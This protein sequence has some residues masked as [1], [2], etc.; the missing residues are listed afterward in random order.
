MR[1]QLLVTLISVFFICSNVFSQQSSINSQ[2]I[3]QVKVDE[4]SDEQIQKIINQAEQSGMT[5]QQLEQMV[6]ARGLPASELQKLKLRIA[7]LQNQTDQSQ[8]SEDASGRQ[9]KDDISVR[10]SFDIMNEM[11][12]T[13]EDTALTE[14]DKLKQK[15]FG[16][17]LFNNEKLT[18]SP[19]LNIATPENYIIGAGD[20]INIDIWGASQQNYSL[21]VN[22]EGYIFID[23]L[24]PVYLSGLSIEKANAKIKDKLSSI[25]SGLSGESPNTFL[26]VSLGD[27][28]S[29]KVTVSGDVNLP[30]TYSLPALATAFNALYYAGGPSINGSF[31]EVKIIR[32]GKEFSKFDLYDF[33]VKGSTP[34]NIRL[35][36]ED[37]VFIP[38]CVKRVEIEG[39]VVRPGLYEFLEEESLSDLI[40][41]SGGFKSDAYKS[42]V[43]IFRKGDKQKEVLDIDKKDFEQTE[44]LD[45]DVLLI[46]PIL[47]KYANR[48][49]IRGAV[50]RE[51]VFA[52]QENMT[53]KQLIEKA[54]GYRE[55]AFLTRGY[56]YRLGSNY[57]TEMISFDPIKL[58][59][60]EAED[61]KLSREDFI[62]I[63]SLL[64][65][66]EE[67]LV[68]LEGEVLN[69]GE[70]PYYENLKLGEILLEAG[71]LL[72]SA[73]LARIEVARRIRNSEATK[74]TPGV[75]EVFQ[76][77][78][79]KSL[80]INDIASDF[81]LEPFDVIVIRKSPDYKE[82]QI[83]TVEG[84]VAFPGE[85]ILTHKTERISDIINRAGG[86]TPEAYLKGATLI[87][88][89]E[90]DNE[91][92]RRKALES[93]MRESAD[94]AE[95]DVPMER[96]QAIGI[97]L[98][99]I[100]AGPK[101]KYDLL[102]QEG[103]ILRIPKQL[104]TVRL[105]GALL[106]PVTV[107]YDQMKLFRNYITQAG[108]FASNAK[109]NKA[110]I[111]YAN[112]SVNRTQ[113][114][115]FIRDFPKVEPGAEIVIPAKPPK[116]KMTP[117][118]WVGL[119][120]VLSSTALVLVTVIDKLSN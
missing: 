39:E 17:S 46:D 18:F 71:G 101:S 117:Q 89:V 73:S 41:Y 42:R 26:Q 87:R 90:E 83:I 108:G 92:N 25:Y 43:K 57:K 105:S 100:L 44:L 116:D 94:S 91:E 86:F 74:P 24:G 106:Y 53:L 88:K 11:F 118:E 20:E 95:F 77:P 58:L 109:R 37:I 99:Q 97:D 62:K 76:F 5:Q 80:N 66:E 10:T 4:L 3:S 68:I 85:Y 28:K 33:L 32:G 9:L 13:E 70:Y 52:L 30:G 78:I 21:A 67:K 64:D 75:A 114:F 7:E 49:E 112:G 102:L 98:Q 23:A 93:I 2:D 48:V 36:D 84:E 12:F 60:G 38:P 56:I 111:I 14:E 107:R 96:E 54:E 72:E 110:Y 63:P 119:T 61:I 51:G 81:V 104:Q 50:Y 40:S 45:G 47:N 120:S 22:P 103:D 6:V 113:S 34:T 8:D 15:I 27:L 59:N 16:F 69:P 82:Q 115:I 29:I 35:K 79:S 19:S 31:R 65:L 55:D 1:L